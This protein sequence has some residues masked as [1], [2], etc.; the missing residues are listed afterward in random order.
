MT[1]AP[2]CMTP[3]SALGIELVFPPKDTP[4]RVFPHLVYFAQ[5]KYKH[6]ENKSANKQNKFRFGVT[7]CNTGGETAVART[8]SEIV[9]APEARALGS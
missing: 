3:G 6:L 8:G 2:P 4:C 1:P 9:P 7:V 5:N